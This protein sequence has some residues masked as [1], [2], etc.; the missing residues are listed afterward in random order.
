MT[1]QE[2]VQIL[3]FVLALLGALLALDVILGQLFA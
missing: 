2:L 1:P 3:A